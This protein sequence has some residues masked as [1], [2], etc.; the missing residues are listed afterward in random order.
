MDKRTLLA[1]V[2]SVVII[3]GGMILQSVLAPS[4]PAAQQTAQKPA[5]TQTTPAPQAAQAP[6]AQQTLSSPQAQSAQQVQQTRTVGKPLVAPGAATAIATGKVVETADSAPPPAQPLTI[7]RDTDLY[8]LAFDTAGGTLSAVRLRKYKNV[9]GSLV[10][11]LLLPKTMTPAEMPFSLAFG[12]YKSDQLTIPFA[13]HETTDST[14][15]TFDF[16]RTFY[17]PTGVPFTLHKTYLFYKDEYLFQLQI[18]IENSV[19][20]F[21][22]LDFGGYAYTLTLGPQIG[23]HYAKL[24]GRNDF[25]KYAYWADG[26]RQDPGVGMGQIKEVNKTVTWAGIEGKYFTAIAVPD[27]S[28]SRLVF[29]SRKLVEGYDRSAISFE[30]PG[31]KSVKTTD[32]YRFYM[33]PMK[34]EVLAR[35]NDADKNAFG[36]ASLHADEMV[37]SSI[38]IGWLAQL[39]KYVLD[40]FYLII[41]NYGIAIILLTIFIKVIFLPLTFKSSESTAKMAALNPKIQEIRTR[42]KGKPEKMNQEI[43]ELYRREKIN[44]LSGCLPLLLQI[45]VFFAL[46]NLLNSYFELRGA[47]F[48]PGWIPD[49]SVPEAVV[50]FPFAIPLLGWTAL[51]ALPLLMV[52]SQLLQ[53]KFT[54][55]A[56]QSQ[57]GAQMKL[58]TYALPIIFLFIL[59][60]M[61]SGLVLYWTVQNVLSILQQLY[62]N[63]LKRKRD[64]QA[65][66]ATPVVVKSGSKPGMKVKR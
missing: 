29:D 55:P 4:K 36:V 37:T 52:A 56:D 25:R 20:D 31:L 18:T 49:L 50:N 14:K 58:M 60:D 33:G 40:F 44:P 43:A 39:L 51:R 17:S 13:L 24:D 19:N 16:T 61:P 38:L 48:I 11:M 42:M 64:E 47:M 10:D 23:P 54:Q 66:A 41:P 21:P 62:I 12:D 15:S 30:R 7:Q 22:A 65:S 5:A 26:K 63:S 9:D 8:S 34:K 46:Y 53:G 1:V 27:G 35:Y 45:P 28:V 59:Y 32:T 6:S 2:L 3:V 57:A